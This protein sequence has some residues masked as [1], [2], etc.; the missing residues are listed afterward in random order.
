MIVDFRPPIEMINVIGNAGYDDFRA[1]G[2]QFLNHFIKYECVTPESSVLDVGCGIGRMAI[3]FTD[4]LSEAGRFE[5]FDVD[6]KAIKWC[7]DNITPLFP[8][9]KFQLSEV[10]NKFYNPNFPTIASEYVFPYNDNEFD[11]VYLTSVFTHMLPIDFENY[12]S[13]ISRVLNPNGVCF[14]TYFLITEDSTALIKARKSTLNCKF[15]VKDCNCLTANPEMPEAAIAYP[16]EYI[17]D[18]YAKNNLTLTHPIFFG[19]WC[20]RKNCFEYQDVIIAKKN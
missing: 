1:G 20:G 9:F 11:F 10:N 6:D 18:T 17:L 5:G 8:N 2:E 16:V 4:Y 14:I 13:E 7:S 19:L 3:P 12:L 15:P